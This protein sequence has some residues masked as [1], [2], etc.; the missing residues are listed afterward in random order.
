MDVLLAFGLFAWG[1]SGI[2]SYC[3]LL[4]LA[5]SSQDEDESLIVREECGV[6]KHDEWSD[7]QTERWGTPQPPPGPPERL[8]SGLSHLWSFCQ[9]VWMRGST[10]L[11]ILIRRLLV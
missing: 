3:L 10:V 5:S 9:E 1:G 8:L 11:I 2:S 4:G 6:Q 7:I